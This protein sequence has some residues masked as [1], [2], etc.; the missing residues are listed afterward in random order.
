M[1]PRGEPIQSVLVL[2]HRELASPTPFVN[3]LERKIERSNK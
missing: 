3:E 1:G 2:G